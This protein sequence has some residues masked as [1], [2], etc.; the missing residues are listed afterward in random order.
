MGRVSAGGELKRNYVS[1]ASGLKKATT[2]SSA[3]ALMRAR[4]HLHWAGCHL[5]GSGCHLRWALWFSCRTADVKHLSARSLPGT[6]VGRAVVLHIVIV[7][8]SDI[9]SV[10]FATYSGLI[11]HSD[12]PKSCF[13]E[14]FSFF[15]GFA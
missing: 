9:L 5:Q 6:P 12:K 15:L 4:C 10:L 3:G 2:L 1:S 7:E 11:G 14:P 8:K 13:Y